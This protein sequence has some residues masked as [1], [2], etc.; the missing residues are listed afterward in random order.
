MDESMGEQNLQTPAAPGLALAAAIDRAFARA[1]AEGRICLV[2]YVM[3]GYPDAQ[4]ST[5][6]ALGLAHGGAE[7]LELGVPFSDPLADGAPIQHAGQVSLQ[8]G[9]TL[10]GVLEVAET[11]HRQVA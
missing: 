2:P 10:A 5:A 7:L 8:G 3:A 4:T 1:K 9:M 6:L 11:I